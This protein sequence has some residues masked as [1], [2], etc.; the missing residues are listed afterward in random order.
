MRKISN[1]TTMANF[2]TSDVH[3]NKTLQGV[4]ALKIEFEKVGPKIRKGSLLLFRFIKM[5]F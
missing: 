5:K 1:Q 3:L 4:S 2:N